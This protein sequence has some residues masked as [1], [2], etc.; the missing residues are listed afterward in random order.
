MELDAA[1]N[2]SK[3]VPVVAGHGYDKD[4]SVNQCPVDSISN[5]DNI[6]VRANGQ[7]VIGEDTGNH[8]NNALWI[9]TKGQQS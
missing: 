3:M 2:V 9:W 7:V 5:P 8:E 6:L 4:A 1:F